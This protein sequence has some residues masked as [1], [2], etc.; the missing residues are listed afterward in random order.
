MHKPLPHRTPDSNEQ[1]HEAPVPPTGLSP[2][3]RARAE[4]GWERFL[5]RWVEDSEGPGHARPLI[6]PVSEA[7]AAQVFR[8]LKAAME[9]AGLPA[10]GL[11]RDVTRGPGGDTHAYGLGVVSVGAAKRLA[12]V[13]HAGRRSR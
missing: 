1:R 11:Y 7:E 6:R 4:A 3:L 9:G 8:E 10:N 13:L 5:D 12:A 2:A